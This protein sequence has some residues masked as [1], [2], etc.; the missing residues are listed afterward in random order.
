MNEKIDNLQALI[1]ARNTF[2][3]HTENDVTEIRKQ[4]L[5]DIDTIIAQRCYEICS[6]FKKNNFVEQATETPNVN[7]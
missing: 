2:V 3:L 5:K 7:H 4:T 1:C 6:E